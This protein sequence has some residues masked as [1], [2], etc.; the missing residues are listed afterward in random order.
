M[1][2][3]KALKALK[4]TKKPKDEE[5]EFISK[6]KSKK[7][8]EIDPF[9]D[10]FRFEEIYESGICKIDEFTYSLTLELQDINYQLSSD[11]H[12][13]EIFSQY[14]DFL[15]SLSS[16]T[17]LQLTVYKKKRPLADLQSVLYYKAKNDFLDSYREEMNQVI[18]RKLDE[19]KNGFK[20]N[21]LIY[22]CAE[23]SYVGDR[24]KRIRD[25]SR[26]F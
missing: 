3:L 10:T 26:S 8:E 25:G 1:M 16:K 6:P 5:K 12:Q 15:N 20:K 2:K 17:K 24:A 19:E 14:C 21:D 22:F 23:T 18:S 9:R 11:D 4:P 7:K 13:I